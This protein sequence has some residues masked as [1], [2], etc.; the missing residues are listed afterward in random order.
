MM[1]FM[2]ASLASLMSPEVSVKKIVSS[3]EMLYLLKIILNFLTLLVS[4][5]DP[6][7]SVKESR[8][9]WRSRYFSIIDLIV[10]ETTKRLWVLLSSRMTSLVVVSMSRVRNFFPYSSKKF[11]SFSILSSCSAS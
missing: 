3:G 11:I 10:L 6:R 8:S 2:F 4:V 1:V 7:I 9:P 5:S